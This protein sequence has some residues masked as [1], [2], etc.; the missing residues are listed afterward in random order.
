MHYQGKD[1]NP[2]ELSEKFANYFDYKVKRI[3][4]SCEVDSNVY[5]GKKKVSCAD[6]NFMRLE[7]IVRAFKN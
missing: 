1:I 7:N 2:T 3:V 4:A 6:K 5:N